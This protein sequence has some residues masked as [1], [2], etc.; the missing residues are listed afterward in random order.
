MARIGEIVIRDEHEIPLARQLTQRLSQLVKLPIGDQARLTT[1]VSQVAQSLFDYSRCVEIRFDVDDA[2]IVFYLRV[3]I[4]ERAAEADSASAPQGSRLSRADLLRWLEGI[5]TFMSAFSVQAAAGEPIVVK[6]AKRFPPWQRSVSPATMEEWAEILRNETPE[7]PIEIVLQQN[8]EL[9]QVLDE[10]REKEAA[11][12]KKISEN[13]A[14]ER[15]RDDLVH[16]LVHDLRNP[17]AS[18]R[19]SLSGLLHNLSAN[20]SPYQRMMIEISYLGAKKMTQLVDDILN[21]YKLEHEELVIDPVLFSLEDVIDSVLQL[22]EPLLEEKGIRAATDLPL[23]LPLVDG[24]K[25]LIER[26]LQNLLD[27]AIK[28]TPAGGRITISAVP[29]SSSGRSRE[30][31]AHHDAVKILVQD[32][33]PGVPEELRPSIFHKFA[34][35]WSP[36]SGSGLGLAFCKLVVQ[37]HGGDIW[38]EGGP[39][40]GARFVFL[41]PLAYMKAVQ[42]AAHA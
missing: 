8:R 3:T 10:L 31:A 27:N 24:D 1:A 11:L 20:T 32:S 33:G 15:M 41:L 40:G 37:A 6:A 42:G 5:G 35:G 12:E 30:R 22:Q 4:A 16:A 2:D 38:V 21:I 25:A 7:G 17:L 9:I 13:E 29:F 26:V 34:T 36:D 23:D 19:S 28:F 18:I 14:L 39:E